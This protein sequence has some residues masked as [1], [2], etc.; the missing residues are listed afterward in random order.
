MRD[1]SAY[2]RAG[3]KA[4]LLAVLFSHG[5]PAAAAHLS[6]RLEAAAPAA[7]R[8]GMLPFDA[9]ADIDAGWHIHSNKPNRPYLIPTE[10]RLTLPPGI[11]TETV[12]YPTPFEK[13]LAF[14]GKEPLLIYE[15]K[16]GIATALLVPEDF[17]GTR[18]RIEAVLR[19]QACSET[20]CLPPAEATAELV[21]PVVEADEADP[22]LLPRR[23][24]A[25]TDSQLT[26][27]LEER[28]L[29]LTLL[30]V[31]A[32]GLGLNLTPCVY[33]LI[34]VTLAY[35]GGQSGSRG[36]LL[37]LAVA[38][39]L[40]IALSFS[41]L[42]VSAALS[43]GLF[44]GALQQPA[45]VFAIAA[46]L[47]VLA[48]GNFGI[49][50]FRLPSALNRLAGHSAR[51]L[52]GALFM[53]LTMGVVAAPCVGPIVLGLL[54]FVGSRQDPLFGFLL[55]FVLALGM[56]APYVL[57]AAGAGAIRKLPRSGEWLLWI[58]HLFGCVLLALAAYFVRPLL[59]APSGAWLLAATVGL[60]GAYLGFLA[61]EVGPRWFGFTRRAI[62]AAFVG[63]AVSLA[64]PA[65]PR[66]AISW[67]P[68]ASYEQAARLI[69]H[70]RPAVLDFAA[71]WCI[72]CREMDETTYADERVLAEA[73][74]FHMLKADV[75][76][77]TPATVEFGEKFDV[78]GVPTVI[79]FDADGTETQR[80]V[81]YTSAD[82]LLAAMRATR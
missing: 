35:F 58:E 13:R 67:Q 52:L 31:F 16:I 53:G 73:R 42:G 10:L 44:G 7:P 6:F 69:G 47:V 80:L 59:P 38:Y 11:S 60:S 71:E 24:P 76:A 40:G 34:S 28:G 74:G 64:L 55:F 19:Y 25:A 72:P 27:W 2:L 14:A 39:V 56:G 50:Q 30:L 62:G 4:F 37:E 15:G 49:Y 18:I 57:L 36:R 51:G 20:T 21:V 77:E 79:L 5:V 46:L 43:G 65:A 63:L 26:R 17:P 33:P 9:V 23:R 78:R 70:G 12:T 82:E 41:A 81:G 54:V 8:G 48:L 3:V 61:R 22:D 1:V 32:L 29:A 45:V 66:P 68:V 75:T